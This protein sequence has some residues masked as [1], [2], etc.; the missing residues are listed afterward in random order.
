MMPAKTLVL[1]IGCVAL[2]FFLAACEEK[3]DPYS[4]FSNLVAERQELRKA[5]SKEREQEKNQT[6]ESE[7]TKGVKT[8]GVK[9]DGTTNML[10]EKQIEITDSVSGK[11]LAK[12]IAYLNKEGNITR[13][14]ILKE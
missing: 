10:Y 12:G 6:P 11:P 1:W 13:I 14:K 8:K 4:G 9:I 2:G 7:K 5:I 3:K